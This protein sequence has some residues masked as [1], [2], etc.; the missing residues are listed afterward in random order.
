MAELNDVS[1]EVWDQPW[2]WETFFPELVR[3]LQTSERQYTGANQQYIDY[4]VDR[5]AMC[6]RNIEILK[7]RL[8]TSLEGA[9]VEVQPVITQIFTRLNELSHALGQLSTK[10][11]QHMDELEGRSSSAYQAPL[12]HA[13]HLRPGRRRFSIT[14][15]QLE[16][17]H[18]SW[19]EIARIL[20]VSR[21]TVHRRRAEYGMLSNPSQLCLIA[22]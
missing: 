20:G 4:V 15:E 3:F 6:T 17:L 8:E 11:Q 12:Q 2:G 9:D 13:S 19:T 22:N 14:K 16:Y 5:L 1:S 21:M 18:F 10:W 7:E